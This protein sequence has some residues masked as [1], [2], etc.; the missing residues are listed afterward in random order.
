MVCS[1]ALQVLF[2]RL[3]AVDVDTG[4]VASV[5]LFCSPPFIGIACQAVNNTELL[6]P[7]ISAGLVGYALGN[8]IGSGTGKLWENL[9][10]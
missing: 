6:L 10:P 1:V 4:I 9:A 2:F 5:Q 7:G 3:T 8:Y